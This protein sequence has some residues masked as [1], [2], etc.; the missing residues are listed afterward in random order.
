MWFVFR[1]KDEMYTMSTPAPIGIQLYTLREALK[2]DFNGTVTRLAEIGYAGVEPFGW[3]PVPHQEAA[4]LFNELGLQVPSAHLPLPL[5][6]NRAMALD[7]AAA[8]GLKRLICPSVPDAI[9]TF[10][11]VD[12]IKAACDMLN[13]ANAV[14]V[15][16]GFEYGYHNHWWEF[17]IVDGRP[18]YKYM[19]KWLDPAIFFEID[20]YWVQAGGI[21]AI[22]YI[23]EL[24]KR[25]PLLHIKDGPAVVDQ[26]MTAVGDG[27]LDVP[28]IVKAAENTA[29]WLIV[30]ID[31]CAT[32]MMEAVRK[33]YT[34]LVEHR[35]GQGK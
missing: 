12:G 26:P 13:E 3:S 18:G 10:K 16:N 20:T 25:A 4:Q 9:E 15:E 5:G 2:N 8:Y 32:D 29:E 17:M 19:L 23:K 11:T 28:A 22:T 7:A 27:V 6:E 31:R 1:E 34:Y 21:D 30:E 14:A 33:S 35:L 24:G